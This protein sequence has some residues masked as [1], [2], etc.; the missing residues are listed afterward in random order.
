MYGV[1]LLEYLFEGLFGYRSWRS[2]CFLCEMV[3]VCVREFRVVF[4]VGGCE[5]P[6]VGVIT[7]V[8]AFLCH[9]VSLQDYIQSLCAPLGHI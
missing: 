9:R 6:G 3:G 4:L 8:W 1:G 7:N 5:G 2:E